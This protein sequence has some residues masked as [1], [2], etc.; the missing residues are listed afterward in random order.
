VSALYVIGPPASGKS[1]A[2]AETLRALGLLPQPHPVILRG[3]LRGHRLPRDGLLLGVI[4]PGRWGTDG[5]SM[6]VHTDAVAWAGTALPRRW[7]YIVGEGARLGTAG[8]LRTLAHSAPPLT[9]VHLSV[10]PDIQ[11]ARMAQRGSRQDASWISG[12]STAASRTATAA[13]A[14]A[15]VLDLDTGTLSPHEVGATL[16]PM[17]AHTLQRR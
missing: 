2:V 3:T 1:T 9:V 12:A 14:F 6:A 8:F 4:R 13:R 7:R 15:S 16:A 17:L 11:T 10:P 5:L